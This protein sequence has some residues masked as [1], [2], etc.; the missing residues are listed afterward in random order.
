MFL[1][2]SLTDV[3]LKKIASHLKIPHF[4]GVFMRDTLPNK[5]NKIESGIINLDSL[6]GEGTHWVAYLKNH[7]MVEY[8]DSYGDLKPPTE[9][10]RYLLSDGKSNEIYYNYTRYQKDDEEIC[11]QL[12]IMFLIYKSVEHGMV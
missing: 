5:I 11:G 9:V 12:C 8:F 1:R 4:K 2:Q 6:S 7:N 3:D 10:V